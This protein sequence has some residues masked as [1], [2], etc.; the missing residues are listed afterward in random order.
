MFR[1]PL[2]NGGNINDGGD[3]PEPELRI[4][5]RQF[6]GNCREQGRNSTEFLTS[7]DDPRF[8]FRLWVECEL[9]YSTVMCTVVMLTCAIPSHLAN[10]FQC[11][12]YHPCTGQR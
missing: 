3:M 6:N 5:G 11:L 8:A 4:V 7:H 9:R 1:S 2:A 10:W 12:P